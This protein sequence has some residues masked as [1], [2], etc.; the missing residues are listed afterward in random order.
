MTKRLDDAAKEA[1]IHNIECPNCGSKFKTN[2]MLRRLF[3]GILELIRTGNIV[4]IP[5]FGMFKPG[6]WT[7]RN[8]KCSLDGID[9]I[10]FDDKIIIKFR[11]ADHTRRVLNP[12]P[13]KER[14]PRPGASEAMRKARA[15]DKKSFEEM[16]KRVKNTKKKRSKKKRSKKVSKK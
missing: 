11:A 1:G 2:P 7:G 4:N 8:V 12:E 14:K 16:K 10:E 15:D 9:R 6:T 13:V 5:K 3:L